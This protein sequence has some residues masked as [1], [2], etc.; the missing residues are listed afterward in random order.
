CLPIPFSHGQAKRMPYNS[1]RG[2]QPRSRRTQCRRTE[3]CA[4]KTARAWRSRPDTDRVC[5]WLELG[6]YCCK[7]WNIASFFLGPRDS[8]LLH[9]ATRRSYLSEPIDAVG[10]RNLPVGKARV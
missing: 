9:S 7:T 2:I 8:T 1:L 6:R 10:G 4:Q 5:G 3:R